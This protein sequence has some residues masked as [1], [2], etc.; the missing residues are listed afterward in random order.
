MTSE[1][2]VI[3]EIR[4]ARRRMSAECGHDPDRY[5]KYLEE[6]SRKYSVQV[7]KYRA[8]RDQLPVATAPPERKAPGAPAKAFWA[9]V[10]T[11]LI[12]LSILRATGS[13]PSLTDARVGTDAPEFRLRRLG[14]GST[15]PLADY[16]G[17][18]LVGASWATP[19]A[20]G[21][22]TCSPWAG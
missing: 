1:Q 19:C 10:A 8:A 5:V 17:P 14:D 15:T 4:E 7:E 2:T 12:V 22:T 16:D 6:F 9:L 18:V 13:D 3:E 20:R 21:R 11:T